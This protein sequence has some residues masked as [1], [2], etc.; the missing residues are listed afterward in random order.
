MVFQMYMEDTGKLQYDSETV[1]QVPPNTVMAYSVIEMTIDS[2]GY[3]G[4][5]HLLYV[6]G[7]GYSFFWLLLLL[8]NVL[9]HIEFIFY[10]NV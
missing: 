9:I 10:L 2:D 4:Q 1:L 8:L 6:A 5:W 3:F 7:E